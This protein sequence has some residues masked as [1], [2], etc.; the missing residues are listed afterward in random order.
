ME[1]EGDQADRTK[2]LWA[3]QFDSWVSVKTLLNGIFFIECI[4]SHLNKEILG[5]EPLFIEGHVFLKTFWIPNF[6]PMRHNL[7]TKPIWITLEGLLIEYL[8]FKALAMIGDALGTFSG[9]DEDFINEKVCLRPRLLMEMNSNRKDVD[10]LEIIIDNGKCL[11]WTEVDKKQIGG[12]C[13]I[14]KHLEPSCSRAQ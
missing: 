9:I 10:D 7:K 5:G 2:E 1:W 4:S 14:W 11:Q 12:R 3:K 13:L 6:N 8:N